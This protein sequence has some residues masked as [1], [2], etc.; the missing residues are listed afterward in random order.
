VE[1]ITCVESTIEQLKQTHWEK[2]KPLKVAQTR[3]SNRQQRPNVEMVRDEPTHRYIQY[4]TIQTKKTP[5]CLLRLIEEVGELEDTLKRLELKTDESE[6]RL[7][8]LQHTRLALEKE[9]SE[10]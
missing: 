6:D 4:Y 7:R 10:A 1:E 3:L 5:N 2:Q 9:V 8:D